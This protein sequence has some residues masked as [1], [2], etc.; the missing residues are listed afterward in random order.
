MLT[1][2]ITLACLSAPAP[3]P[4]GDGGEATTFYVDVNI[5]DDANDGSSPETPWKTIAHALDEVD[6]V[7]L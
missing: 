4:G 5:G 6:V 2:T 7:H 1:L 3:S